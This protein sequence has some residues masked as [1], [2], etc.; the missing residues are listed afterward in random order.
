M[1]LV[2]APSRLNTRFKPI[3]RASCLLLTFQGFDGI[4]RKCIIW[5]L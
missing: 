1:S 4:Q 3:H 5:K 2:M